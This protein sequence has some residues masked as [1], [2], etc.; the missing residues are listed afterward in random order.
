MNTSKT[1]TDVF[2]FSLLKKCLN[3]K[4][5]SALEPDL[6]LNNSIDIHEIAPNLNW[7]QQ[8]QIKI[9]S[10]LSNSFMLYLVSLLFY[11][12]SITESSIP[13]SFLVCVLQS[14][15]AFFFS[16]NNTT[17]VQVHIQVCF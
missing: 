3:V 17:T 15:A 14:Y 16:L 9:K 6:Y 8:D 5:D 2:A 7:I 10:S 13:I 4:L 11:Y 1:N 12:V